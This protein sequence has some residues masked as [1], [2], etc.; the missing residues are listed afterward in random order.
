VAKLC[1]GFL[2]L[3]QSSGFAFAQPASTDERRPLIAQAV[4]TGIGAKFASGDNAIISFNAGK[5]RVEGARGSL[6]IY[7]NSVQLTEVSGFSYKNYTAC[8]EVVLSSFERN[9]PTEDP[10]KFYD[11]FMAAYE[12]SDALHVGTCLQSAASGG[13]Y[14]GDMQNNNLP[15]QEDFI[16]KAV[17]SIGKS[18]ERRIKRVFDRTTNVTETLK[19]DLRIYRLFPG[20][21]YPYFEAEKIQSLNEFMKDFASARMEDYLEL[22]RTAGRMN[23]MFHSIG[24]LSAFLQTTQG[25]FD[26]RA[27]RA[28]ASFPPSLQCLYQLYSQDI[29]RLKQTAVDVGIEAMD[30]PAVQEAVTAGRTFAA[31]SG[32]SP[33][34]LFNRRVATRV[35]QAIRTSPN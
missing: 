21:L 17:V 32:P 18:V 8:I 33:R 1:V 26:D 13:L 31:A 6:T 23:R 12:L 4:C 25:Q 30:V 29:A 7:E 16:A 19:R 2:L 24:V 15:T 9:R 35:R 27:R 5:F 11:A 28:N 3:I 14:F 34:D 10:N 20:R 22:G